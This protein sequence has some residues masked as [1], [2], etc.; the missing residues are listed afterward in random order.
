MTMA[1]DEAL[2]GMP[3]Q[4]DGQ[5]SL[6]LHPLAHPELGDI[7]IDDSLFA[8]GR[9][10]AP[11]ASYAPEVVADLSRRH[12][13]IFVEGGKAYLADLGSKN[14]TT[15]NGATVQHTIVCLH[16][17]D[18]I[19]FGRSLAYR[20]QVQARTI[21][22][23]ARPARLA[24]LTLTPEHEGAGL[25]QIV[26]TR[27][28]FLV[29]KA[30]D[31]FA[32]YK[33]AHAQQLN[34]LSRRHAH[35][36]LKGGVP[37]VEDLGS[38][39]GTFIGA[40]RLDEH[41]HELKDGDVLAF[42]GHHFVYRVSLQWEHA[43]PDP[44]VTRIAPPPPVADVD[45]TTFVAAADSFLNIFCADQGAVQEDPVNVNPQAAAAAEEP[46]SRGRFALMTAALLEAIGAAGD[47]DKARMKR[48]AAGILMV[49]LAVV[50]AMFLVGAPERQIRA[51]IAS[52]DYAT[53]AERANA[54]LSGKAG[55]MELRA[56]STEAVL[57]AEL[58][59]WMTLVAAGRFD[60]ASAVVWRMRDLG[61]HNADLQPLIA[62]I[63]WLGEVERYVNARGGADVP[64]KGQA[65]QARIDSI[66]KQW[67]GDTQAHQRAY[68]TIS[69]HVP[70]FRDTYAQTLSDIRKLALAGGKGGT[71]G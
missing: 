25:E 7:R 43:S 26:V 66:V 61:R 55:D 3:A 5:V 37:Y 20:V 4:A 71:E 18:E 54:R 9:S 63:F 42:G 36:F 29:S 22:P 49:A 27:F 69:A 48:W 10:E 62:E 52:G 45:K 47:A 17:G 51:L 57:K 19:G 12:A 68:A 44:T 70:A 13:R 1:P 56:L 21:P 60:Q 67:E 38:T 59:R 15:V 34:Y 65:D 64:V 32:R 58:P 16:D 2:H 50:V 11:F 23:S 24:S 53:A 46:T 40:A 14:G 33:D 41:A 6:V 28:P 31:A 30:D 8:V 39:N 35:I